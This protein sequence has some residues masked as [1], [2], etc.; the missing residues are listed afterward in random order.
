[1]MHIKDRVMMRGVKRRFSSL[2]TLALTSLLSD[3]T[4]TAPLLRKHGFYIPLLLKQMLSLCT[5]GLYMRALVCDG[6]SNL[7]VFR[8]YCGYTNDEEKEIEH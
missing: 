8:V 4:L 3:H 1:M 6:T 5:N 7:S 2:E